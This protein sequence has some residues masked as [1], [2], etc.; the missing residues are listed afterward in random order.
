MDP[1]GE[2]DC[3]SKEFSRLL[4]GSIQ[5]LL[6]IGQWNAFLRV[7]AVSDPF[8]FI[9]D[10][11]KYA[12]EVEKEDQSKGGFHIRIF[13]VTPDGRNNKIACIKALRLLMGWG[14]ADSKWSFESL[15]GYD[16]TSK[17]SNNFDILS[18]QY[19]TIEEM[20]ESTEYKEICLVTPYMNWE[21][22]R[23]PSGTQ[24]SNPA[25]SVR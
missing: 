13:G 9:E 16:T 17:A 5:R 22:A 18:E 12:D 1:V 14:L 19:S 2:N 21:I 25:P 24:Q 20:K 6:D 15:P 23:R 3:N 8:K 11:A 4:V 7:Q 10:V